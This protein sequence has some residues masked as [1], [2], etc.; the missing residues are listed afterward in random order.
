MG[1]ELSW[2]MTHRPEEPPSILDLD[3]PQPTQVRSELRVHGVSSNSWGVSD[4]SLR[5][6]Q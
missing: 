5:P 6:Q 4:I 2:S 1:S 3:L